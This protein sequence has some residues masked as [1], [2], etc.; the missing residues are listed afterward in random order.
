[1]GSFGGFLGKPCI[2]N[3]HYVLTVISLKACGVGGC[4]IYTQW[5]AESDIKGSIIDLSALSDP[6]WLLPAQKDWCAVC[7][8]TYIQATVAFLWKL[9]ILSLLALEDTTVEGSLPIYCWIEDD[10]GT[11]FNPIQQQVLRTQRSQ[12]P[13]HCSRRDHI[14]NKPLSC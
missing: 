5:F 3:L 14:T 10:Q 9:K 7:L 4:S 6:W 13:W 12:N 8:V 1:M 11:P 2:S